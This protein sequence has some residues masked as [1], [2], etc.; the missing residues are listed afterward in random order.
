MPSLRYLGPTASDT[1]IITRLRLQAELSGTLS[2]ELVDQQ[3]TTALS[4]KADLTYLANISSQKVGSSVLT[5]K[6]ANLIPAS[7]AGHPGG[8]LVNNPYTYLN[9]PESYSRPG[10]RG[11]QAISNYNSS[12]VSI[13]SGAYSSTTEQ[14]IANFTLNGPS[15][16]WFPVFTGYFVIGLGKGEICIKQGSRYIARAIGGNDP[17]AWFTCNV[18]P[19]DTLTSYTG[20]V[21]F[22][23]TRRAMFSPGSMNNTA[24]YMLGCMSVPA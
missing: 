21:S 24:D 19:V 22:T 2:P 1:D 12:T 15:F 4:T 18:V 3:T 5:A 20:S 16:P 23:I 8:P 13:T 11:W 6:T 9:M 14:V 10:G 7:D 17:N